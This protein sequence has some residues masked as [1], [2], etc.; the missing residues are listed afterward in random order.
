MD[1]KVSTTATARLKRDYMRLLKD[2]VP[3][4]KA[5]PTSMNILVWHYVVFGN[6]YKHFKS[7][8]NLLIE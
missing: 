7:L 5:A 1:T 8:Y 3:Y 2:P 4:I 6:F